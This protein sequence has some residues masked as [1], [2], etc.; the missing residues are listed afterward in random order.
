[1]AANKSPYRRNGQFADGERRCAHP[2]CAEAGDYRAP[3]PDSATRH[4]DGPPLWR[5]LCL[6][7]VRE[8][9][10][11]YNYF[12]GMSSE[13]IHAAQHPI[14]SWDSQRRVYQAGTT[15]P[16]AWSDFFDPLDAIAARF[17]G[18]SGNSRQ[19]APRR[20]DA[21]AAPLSSADQA[22]LAVLGLG[23]EADRTDIR[24]RYLQLVRQYHPDRNGGDRSHE[25]RLANVI[26]AYTHLRQ[27]AAL[28]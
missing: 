27:K 7:H 18:P 12:A 17:R 2:G 16:P 21:A 28:R 14:H 19:S 6:A 4:S 11:G 25:K 9:N 10:A 3:D 8:F 23:Q 20:A 15:V 13:D 26:S 1:M 22:A 24:K 5:Y